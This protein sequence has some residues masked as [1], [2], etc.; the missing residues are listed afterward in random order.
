LKLGMRLLL[1]EK[2]RRER[3]NKTINSDLLTFDLGFDIIG[4]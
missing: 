1:K 2:Q 4:A 3:K